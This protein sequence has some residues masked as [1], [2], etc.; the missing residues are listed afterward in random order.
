MARLMDNELEGM[1]KDMALKI[2]L[3]VYWCTGS[4]RNRI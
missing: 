3:M 4:E 2:N 1:W